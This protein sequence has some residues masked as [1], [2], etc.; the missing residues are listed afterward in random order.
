LQQTVPENS[1]W[2]IYSA[3]ALSSAFLAGQ[4]M[5]WR[6]LQ[7]HGLGISS[8]ARVAFFYLLSG[9]HALQIAIGLLAL[10]WIVARQRK[11]TA[12]G[13][14]IATDLAT[15]YFS[16]MAALWIVVLCFVLFA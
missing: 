14:Y 10:I 5:M 15:W 8:N 13:R 1:S 11:W 16:A 7:A 4:S 6:L 12:M 2:W 9:T 3:I